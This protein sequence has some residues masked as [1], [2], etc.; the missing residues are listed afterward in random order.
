MSV[1]P[2]RKIDLITIGGHVREISHDGGK[3]SV[4][5]FTCL[6]MHIAEQFIVRHRFGID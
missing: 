5:P 3:Q 4:F 6:S 2:Q 1:P